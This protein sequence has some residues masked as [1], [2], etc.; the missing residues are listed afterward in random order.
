MLPRMQLTEAIV[1]EEHILSFVIA[2]AY[3]VQHPKETRVNPSRDGDLTR[4]IEVLTISME[5]RTAC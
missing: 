3:V 5:G 4:R 2:C 1:S